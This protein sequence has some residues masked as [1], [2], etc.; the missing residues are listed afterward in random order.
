MSNLNSILVILCVHGV[1]GSTSEGNDHIYV[2]FC[3]RPVQSNRT[4]NDG[5]SGSLSSCYTLLSI[6]RGIDHY[7]H[8]HELILPDLSAIFLPVHPP[9]ANAAAPLPLPSCIVC[10][11][12]GNLSLAQQQRP[13]TAR[14]RPVSAE[15]RTVFSALAC[16]GDGMNDW[17]C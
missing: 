17:T 8:V 16:H 7:R 11:R 4:T 3:Y 9:G 13:R 14:Y 15:W 12:L 2:Y 10:T 5:R 1:H 6:A